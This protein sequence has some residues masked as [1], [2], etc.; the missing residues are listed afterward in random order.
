MPLLPQSFRAFAFNLEVD[1]STLLKMRSNILVGFCCLLSSCLER[2]DGKL[3]V[4]NKSK[5][6]IVFAYGDRLINDSLSLL[7]PYAINQRGKPLLTGKEEQTENTNF[8]S[9]HSEKRIWH[10]GKWDDIFLDT[11]FV[12]NK[13]TSIYILDSEIIRS[14]SWNEIR[15][16]NLILARIYYSRQQ[17]D[18]QQWRVVYSEEKS[19]DKKEAFIK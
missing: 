1:T 11:S 14:Y 16:K 4:I 13:K 17:L 5:R 9:P 8:I 12:A 3:V 6:T 10:F 15:H 18:S 19:L 7:P 2:S